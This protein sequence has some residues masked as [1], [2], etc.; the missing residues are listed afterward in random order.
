MIRST[1]CM[2][3]LLKMI[4]PGSRSW[5]KFLTDC[6]LEVETVSNLD[7][8]IFELKTKPHRLAVVDLSLSPNDHNNL[9]G[10]RVLDAV[11]KLDPNCRT[12]LLTGFA[13]VELAVTAL[14]DFGAFTFLRKESF[15]R[16]QFR[17]IDFTGIGQCSASWSLWKTLRP[18]N[19]NHC[20]SRAW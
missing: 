13:T 11:R 2:H 7:D 3:W 5:Q 18:N 4:V 19:L 1:S 20:H 14:T 12:I 17:E 16:G 9:D 8:A 6:G 10:L 15:H